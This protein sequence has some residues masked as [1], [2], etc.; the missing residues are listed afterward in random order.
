M[1]PPARIPIGLRLA[2]VAKATSRAFDEAME[3]VGGSRAAWLILLSL[4]TRKLGNQRELAQEVGIEGA[5]LTHHLNALETDGLVRRSRDPANRRA[6]VV[7]LTAK[8]ESVFNQLRAAASAFDRR[9]RTNLSEE[10]LD[11][12]EELLERLH[13]N[14]S[15]K[16][17]AL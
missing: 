16:N 13:Q 2:R 10:E 3:A 12:L 1:S 15:K 17:A 6:H 9:L 5:T 4:K 11:R 8:G 14:V 7:E